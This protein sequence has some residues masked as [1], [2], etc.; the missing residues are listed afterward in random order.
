MVS[1]LEHHG[2]AFLKNEQ[3]KLK[4]YLT[5]FFETF[6]NCAIICFGTFPTTKFK[7]VSG[8]NFSRSILKMAREFKSDQPPCIAI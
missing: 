8:D 5:E 7:I 2:V 6:S 4:G 1:S 3:S